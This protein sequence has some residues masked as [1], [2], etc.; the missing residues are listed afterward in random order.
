MD[1]R[2]PLQRQERWK[3][4]LQPPALPHASEQAVHDVKTSAGHPQTFSQQLSLHR[5]TVVLLDGNS[6]IRSHTLISTGPQSASLQQATPPA[7]VLAQTEQQWHNPPAERSSC[8]T[9]LHLHL[10]GLGSSAPPVR[11]SGLNQYPQLLLV[12]G[13]GKLLLLFTP[14]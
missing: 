1:Y 9:L 7:P 2:E 11:S 5:D 4:N 10:G 3:Q 12:F 14:A 8:L 6:K 13:C